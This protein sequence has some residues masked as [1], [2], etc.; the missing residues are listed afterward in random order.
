MI[1]DGIAAWDV[2]VLGF[3]GTQSWKKPVLDGLGCTSAGFLLLCELVAGTCIPAKAAVL[4]CCASCPCGLPE[5]CC[6]ACLLSS[7]HRNRSYPKPS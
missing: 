6:P 4:C 7:P 1:D 3:S 5:G 2:H